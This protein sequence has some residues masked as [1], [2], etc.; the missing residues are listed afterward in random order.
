[1]FSLQHDFCG[2]KPNMRIMKKLT[3][4]VLLAVVVTFS[5]GCPKRLVNIKPSTKFNKKDTFAANA[6]AYLKSAQ[7]AYDCS[8]RGYN[9]Q[10]AADGAVRCYDGANAPNDKTAGLI[11]ARYIRDSVIEDSLTVVDDN[12]SDFINDLQ[13]GRA[14]S[15]FVADVIEIGTSAAIGISKGERAIQI[16][17]IGLTAFRGGRKSATLNFYKEQSTPILINQM[18]DGRARIYASMLEKKKEKDA[19]QYPMKEVIRDVVAY[20][21][22][23][24]LTRAFAD[25]SKQTGAQAFRSEQRVLELKDTPDPST[26]VGSTAISRPS[27]NRIGKQ[28]KAFDRTIRGTDDNAKKETTEKLRLIYLDLSK[29]EKSVEF[30]PVLDKIKSEKAALKED[31]GKL[32][33][34]DE[35][36]SKSV[37]GAEILEILVEIFSSLDREKQ[38]NLF[39]AYDEILTNRM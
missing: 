11:T 5:T 13:L 23:G 14:T 30:K 39:A 20:Y 26:I 1:M 28:L 29:G 36:I 7:I 25:L 10:M 38:E 34:A 21:N 27:G 2:F 17:G 24:T 22:A 19:L 37:T 3:F 4:F 12:Y 35:T 32:D 33:N 8:V 6:N 31:M 16:L 18:D 15:N 9:Y